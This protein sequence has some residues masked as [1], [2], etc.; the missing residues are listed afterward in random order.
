VKHRH[1]LSNILVVASLAIGS[2][3]LTFALER[4]ITLKNEFTPKTFEATIVAKHRDW[5][6]LY[7]GGQNIPIIKLGSTGDKLVTLKIEDMAVLKKNV[8]NLEHVYLSSWDSAKTKLQGKDTDVGLASV[9]DEYISAKKLDLKSGSWPTQA[10]YKSA[11]DVIVLS[12]WAAK[13]YLGNGSTI[14]KKIT[15]TSLGGGESKIVS[16]KII[17][18][19]EAKTN[20]NFA[21]ASN[22]SGQIGIVPRGSGK[23]VFYLQDVQ[24]INLTLAP[25]KFKE[26]FASLKDFVLSHYGQGVTTRSD[27]TAF[28]SQSSQTNSISIVLILFSSGGLILS[29]FSL[30]NLALARVRMGRREIGIRAALGASKKTI[31][32]EHLTNALYIGLLGGALGG[33]LAAILEL[34]TQKLTDTNVTPM[35]AVTWPLLSLSLVLGALS[36]LIFSFYPAWEASRGK[37]AEILRQ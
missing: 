31:L 19:F 14:G 34:V 6:A 36:S 21:S 20:T 35:G 28:E 7:Q 2:C 11:S 17:G 9:T 27:I 12:A 16:Y 18:T 5:S 3:I 30:T 10:E 15:F 23:G 22:P 25:E 1:I 32:L 8:S 24:E 26:S 33:L 4:L 13:K 29:S 37:P